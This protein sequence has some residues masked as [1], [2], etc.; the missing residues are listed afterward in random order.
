[1]A[2]MTGGQA[3]VRSLYREGVRVV[4]GLP[5]VQLYHAMD[6]FYDEPGIRF[7]TTR[8][9]QA[10]AYMADGFSRAGGGIGT[11]LV[12]PGPGLLNATA[13]MNTAYAASSP[14]LM[15]SGQIER[16]LIGVNRGMLHEVDDQLDIMKTVTKF[17]RRAMD[18]AEVPET[19]HEAF[20][21]VKNGRPRPVEIEIPPETLAEVADVELLEPEAPRP[22]APDAGRIA[23]AARMLAAAEN[24]LIWAGGGT[25]SSGASDAVRK[26]AE[27]LQMPVIATAEGKGIISDR[28][29]LSLG[30]L[31]LRNDTVAG[32]D[33]SHDLVLAVGTR[34]AFPFWLGGQQVI[35][36]DV[37]SEELGR[38]YSNTFGVHGDARASLEALL[39]EVSKLAPARA[40]RSA[41]VAAERA[42]REEARISVEPQESFLAAVRS[43]MPDDG[44]LIAGM[45][46]LGYYSRAY[47]PVYEP[48]TFI[49]SSYSGNLGYAY[50]TA[51]G[52]KVAQ[53]DKAV[54]ALS[55]DGGF[56]YNSQ[57]MATAVQYGINAVVV[58]FNDNAYG[59]VLRDQR[60][61]FTGRTIG[62]ELHNPD[63]M[64]LADAYGMNGVRVETPE[65]LETALK[66][67]LAHDG[68][69][70][71]EVPVGPMPT[72]FE[73][74][75]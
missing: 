9:E 19:V 67:C 62:A 15:V 55:G 71:I 73:R 60:N 70:L 69:S 20:H 59:N 50:P 52:A 22:L 12:V 37:D 11:A 75:G 10:T 7:I 14:M 45:T 18:P 39:T 27:H 16:D 57:E 29:P 42:Q 5:G 40:D 54:V 48:R 25:I 43:A 47:F 32:E 34:L 28:H 8:H 21:H 46:Q 30:S 33:S 68:P 66:Q 63:F 38:N 24:P 3:L 2:K 13:A 17:A 74:L 35:Q 44:I 49:T 64:K 61:R 36:I 65:G 26:L 56:M 51:L 31:W 72:P 58:V 53:P 6:A 1:M 4:F 23:E 41:E